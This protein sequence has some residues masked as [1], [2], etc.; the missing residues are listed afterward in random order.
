MVNESLGDGGAACI[1]AF[2]REGLSESF[3]DPA[4]A[5]L[6]TRGTTVRLSSRVAAIRTEAGAVTGLG[7][8]TLAD[9]E[10]VVLAVPAPVASTLLPS[11]QG[12]DAFEAI[13]NVHFKLD[14]PEDAIPERAGFMGMVGSLSEW[15]F[16][17]PGVVSVT[18]SAA[19]R[20]AAMDPVAVA[21]QVWQEVRT[22]LRLPE[23]IP[24]WRV[25]REKRATFSAT[26]EQNRRRPSSSTEFRN[27]VLAGDWTATG[28]P[29]TIE[30]AIRSG[31]RAADTLSSTTRE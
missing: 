4:V 23:P 19:N 17:K 7:A 9:D 25:L 13:L 12:P 15:V 18:I 1:P 29:A 21:Q 24:P 31:R 8:D 16:V 6:E 11:V 3:I 10:A 5:W 27:L 30:G 20:H 2:P 22:A 14:V 26:P 28:L